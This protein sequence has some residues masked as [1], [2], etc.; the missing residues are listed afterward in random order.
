MVPQHLH[1]ILR[2]REGVVTVTGEVFQ[3]VA[4]VDRMHVQRAALDRL[5]DVR[6]QVHRAVAGVHRDLVSLGVA[7]EHRHLAIGEFVLV[8]VHRRGGDHEQRFFVGERVGEEAFA[9]HGTGVFRDTAGPGRDRAVGITGFFR[10][11]GGKR[12]AELGGF[13]GRYRGHHVGGQQAEG[14]YATLQNHLAHKV[15]L[16]KP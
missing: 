13:L 12:G 11:D 4:V 1:A 9:V 2:N 15:V 3:A 14:Q 7:L 10:A 16:I 5:V 6:R 8:L